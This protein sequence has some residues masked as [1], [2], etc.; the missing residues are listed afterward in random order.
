[1]HVWIALVDPKYRGKHLSTEVD[2]AC[3]ENA[4]RKGFDYAYAEFTNDLSEKVSHQFKVL[5]VLNRINF[6]DFKMEDGSKPF[7]G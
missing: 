4:A 1:M 6:E 2:M 3:I 5:Q 7:I